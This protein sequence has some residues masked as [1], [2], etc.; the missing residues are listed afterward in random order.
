MAIEDIRNTVR[1]STSKIMACVLVASIPGVLASIQVWGIGIVWNLVWM[2]VLCLVV[3]ICCLL[4]RGWQQSR[5]GIQDLSA[6]VTGLILA[7]C[8]PPYAS[9]HVLLTASIVAIGLAKH[10]YGGL[11]RN[12]FNPAMVGF[13]AILISFP[14]A[15]TTWPN[16]GQT[17]G[18]SGATQL[19]DFRYRQ[20]M[21]ANEFELAFA[22][23]LSAQAT[24]AAMFTLGGIALMV[25][26]IISW[27]IPLGCLIGL[28]VAALFGYD[29]GSSLSHGS[30]IFHAMS[31]G[32]AFAMFFVATDP[33]SHPHDLK[34]QIFFGAL[35]GLLT[36]LIRAYGIFPDG[37][38]F[39]V[40]LANCCTPILNRIRQAP[41][42]V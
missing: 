29:Q 33:V 24:I 37:I 26:K 9:I 10:A 7:L 6:V 30:L 21:T 34:H 36:Y 3:E 23:T 28:G 38:A 40:L 35:V 25:L 22:A 11:G 39:A 12:I 27:H 5:R 18:L 32:F 4:P 20:G 42:H 17:D 41:A 16:I 15:L 1:G 13:A 19:S 31:G 14:E 2:I 8:L